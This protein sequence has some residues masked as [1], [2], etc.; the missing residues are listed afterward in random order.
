MSPKY[1]STQT[2]IPAEG[3]T[4]SPRIGMQRAPCDPHWQPVETTWYLLWPSRQRWPEGGVGIKSNP[5]A[6]QSTKKSRRPCNQRT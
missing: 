1:I 4:T 2:N 6:R 5:S 3:G